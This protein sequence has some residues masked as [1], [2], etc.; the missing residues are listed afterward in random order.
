MPNSNDDI[1]QPPAD[2][3]A[4]SKAQQLAITWID[5]KSSTYSYAALRGACNCAQCV[6][7]WTGKRRY[8]PDNA[9]PDIKINALDPV[10]N[11][12]IRITWSD[13]HS[14]GLYTWKRLRDE[15]AS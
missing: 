8:F 1:V 12:A 4:R 15:L 3:K 9:P 2:I 11:Y 10:G 14:S 6:D 7:E 13:G 5:G